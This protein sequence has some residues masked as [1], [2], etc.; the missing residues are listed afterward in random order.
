MIYADSTFYTDKYLL[1]R[2]EVVPL[3]EF[4]FWARKASTF[5][6][7][8]TFDRLQG[9][10]VPESVKMCACE[11]AEAYWTDEQA[12]SLTA[13]RSESVGAYSVSYADQTQKQEDF[14]ERLRVILVR[15]LGNS[16]LLYRGA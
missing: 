10:V 3:A 9:A 6:D 16:E 12:N 14:S 8:S 15:W 13:K 5:I 7:V 4:G 2:S 11:I 1:G